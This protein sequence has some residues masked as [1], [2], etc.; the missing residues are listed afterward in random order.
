MLVLVT[1]QFNIHQVESVL[2]GSLITISDRDLLVLLVTSV[3]ATIIGGWIFN[4][5][6]LVSFNPVMARARK[7]SPVLTDYIFV[8][9]LTIVVVA[10]L[11]LVGALLVLVL[12]VVP[13]A[14][15]QNIAGNLKSFFWISTLLSTIST[16]FGL[17]V[18]GFLPVPTGG[19]IVLV[20]SIIFYA[21]LLMRTIFGR[22]GVHQG[23]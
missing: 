3:S 15:A 22:S 14:G 5:S 18:S 2:F 20:S 4:R 7:L 21:T 11:K 1:K 13:A 16:V 10:S 12:I 9:I 23:V 17:L 6:M 19:C 8:V